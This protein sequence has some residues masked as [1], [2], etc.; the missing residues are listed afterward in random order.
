MATTQ[1]P[2]TT[3]PAKDNEIAKT[4]QNQSLAMSEKFTNHVL[5]EFGS[6]VAGALQVTDYQ[7]QLIQ[8]YFIVIDRALKAAEDE[9]LGCYA[10]RYDGEC[11]CCGLAECKPAEP[12]L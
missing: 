6:N 8:G 5:R 1:K 4:D 2:A 3:T 10:D 12:F 11:Q 9:R 7:R